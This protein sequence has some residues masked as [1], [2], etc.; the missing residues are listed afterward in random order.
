[1][2]F[3]PLSFE[4]GKHI[5]IER[6]VF[7]NFGCTFLDGADVRIGEE[8]IV[9]PYVQFI[10]A[11]HAPHHRDR[12][13]TDENGVRIGRWGFNK[14]ITVGKRC[15]I[16]ASAILLPGVT[17]GDDTVIGAGSV[18]TKP[19]PSGVIAAGNPCRI[20]KPNP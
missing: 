16:G 20:I 7:I 13:A 6:G 9:A 18:V 4:Y 11:A 10:T 14:P 8:A 12:I 17:I 3:S 2:V 5:F 19:I 1:M 15:W